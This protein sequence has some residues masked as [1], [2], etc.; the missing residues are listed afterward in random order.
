MRFGKR[1]QTLCIVPMLLS[2]ALSISGC[3]GSRE[4]HGFEIPESFDESRKYEITFW[5]KN[6]TNKTQT[7][8]YEKAIA[9]FEKLY[10]NIDVTIRLYT[11]YGKIYNDVITNIST[12]TTPNVCIT[13]PDHIATYLTGQDTVVP[14]DDLFKD[15]RYGLGGSEV[16]FDGPKEDEIIPQF[17]SECK[18]G[19]NH[20]AV[21][22]MRS[23]EACYVNKDY[24]EKLGFEM[25][26]VLTWDFVW[27]VSE[28]A[29]KKNEDGT[30]KLN[31]QKVL[32]PFIYKSTDNMMIQMLKQQGADYSDSLGNIKLFNDTTK[33]NLETIARHAKSGAFSTF[34]ISGYP[35]NFLNA[36][37]CIFAVDSTAGST[38][39]G[40]NAPL[41]DI[42]KDKI[43]DF[44]TV[45]YP[46]PQIVSTDSSLKYEDDSDYKLSG[47]EKFAMISQGPSLCVFNKDDP[48]EVLASWLFAQYMLTNDVQIAYAQTEG[49]VPVTSKAQDSEKY[50]N[51][52]AKAG[53]DNKTYYDIKIKATRLL[54][55]NQQYTFT[56]DVFN[57]SASLRDAAGQLIENVTKA[58]RRKT[59]IDDAYIDKLYE[60]TSSLYHLDQS[61]MV[62]AGKA[63]LGELPIESRR[64]IE[65]L[66]GVWG[67][68]GFYLIRKFYRLHKSK[69]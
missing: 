25:P 65:I 40:T 55:E 68:I 57:G 46:V 52:L 23:T 34:K 43:V 3:H 16:K 62:A 37:Q 32:I 41:C 4:A 63:E 38:W 42:A 29:A 58:V 30:F 33:G 66:I 36:G 35:A 14:L 9:D 28:A 54:L 8:I 64:L 31:G 59:E 21:P 1:L 27:K 39:M 19:E 51:Y 56:T 69:L 24:V 15:E 67:L 20:Y 10:P 49:Y 2:A 61:S 47:N 5:A 26:K 45:V 44:E 53:E 48:Q 6:D 12:N 17:L 18:I 22:Y 13:Y 50:Q 11:D 60:D 7:N